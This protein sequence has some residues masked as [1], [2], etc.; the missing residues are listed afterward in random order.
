MQRVT[1]VGVQ[2]FLYPRDSARA[3]RRSHS[4]RRHRWRGDVRSGGLDVVVLRDYGAPSFTRLD[5]SSASRY[6]KSSTRLGRY[7]EKKFC[8]IFAERVSL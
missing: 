3:R 1:Y 4:Q 8:K 5:A 2:A 7:L 6:S